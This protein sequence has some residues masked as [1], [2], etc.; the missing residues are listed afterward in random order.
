MM[1]ALSV[2]GT[3]VPSCKENIAINGKCL[4]ARST[5]KTFLKRNLTLIGEINKVGQRFFFVTTCLCPHD[6]RMQDG[7]QFFERM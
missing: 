1:N 4:R 6:G 5:G 3:L 2:A 7:V